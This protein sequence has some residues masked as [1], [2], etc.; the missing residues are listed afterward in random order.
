MEV[1][2]CKNCGRLFNFIG[3]AYRNLCPACVDMME[4]RFVE[5]K[6]Y[7]EDNPHCTI[8]D[9]TDAIDVSARQIEKWI[10]EDRLFFAD[11]SPIGIDCEKCGAMIK[12]GR[13]CPACKSDM[14]NQ[15]S[16]LYKAVVKQEP[17]HKR[18][19]SSKMR[20]LDKE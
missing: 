8:N 17:V 13:F 9:I 10:R 7:I 2:N 3:G 4:D 1:R 19:G 20:Y 15:M 16:N 12:S 5:V 14:E 18:S 11:D 6:K